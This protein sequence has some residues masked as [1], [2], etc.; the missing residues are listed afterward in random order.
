[1]IA[2]N[3]A[4]SSQSA[5]KSGWDLFRSR[6][7]RRVQILLL[8]ILF[9]A[10]CAI[11]ARLFVFPTTGM[12]SRVDAIVVPGG[13]GDRIHAGEK[14]ALQN[15]A[16]YLI[17]SQGGYV[18]PE[19]CGTH[20]GTA[21]VLCFR[22]SPDTT[23]GESRG[24]ARFAREY[25][26]KSIVLVTTPDQ[27]WRAKLWFGRCYAGKIYAVT[28]PLPTLRWPFQIVYQW[29]ATFKAEVLDRSC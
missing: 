12:P 17:L 19:L 5:A 13:P 4:V 18:P 15:R 6:R 25:G 22:P 29:G 7:A 3:P 28:T 14:L 20:V 9:V 21:K 24:T 11:S 1:M 2:D 26:I 23:Q 8:A 16:K 10:F 27:T